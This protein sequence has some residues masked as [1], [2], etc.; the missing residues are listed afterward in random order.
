MRFGV[1]GVLPSYLN[2]KQ[3]H[4]LQSSAELTI[5][6]HPKSVAAWSGILCL[7]QA[8][9]MMDLMKV[10]NSVEVMGLVGTRRL[11]RCRHT[12]FCGASHCNRYNEKVANSCYRKLVAS[13]YGMC[14]HS[15]G[16]GWDVEVLC[17]ERDFDA[18]SQNNRALNRAAGDSA[19]K[20]LAPTILNSTLCG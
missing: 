14:A 17:F 15:R 19:Q 6:E 10:V 3:P 13:L 1:L 4:N 12:A 20:F 8:S 9:A 16:Y 7:A 11:R 18:W 2:C 5:P